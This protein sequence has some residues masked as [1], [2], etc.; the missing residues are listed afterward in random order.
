[1][2][3]NNNPY[4]LEPVPDGIS[5]DEVRIIGPEEERRREALARLGEAA[6]GLGRIEEG[7]FERRVVDAEAAVDQDVAD[8]VKHAVHEGCEGDSCR[9]V[10]DIAVLEIVKDGDQPRTAGALSGMP[11]GE[12]EEVLRNFET[13]RAESGDM[14]EVLRE[15]DVAAGLPSLDNWSPA[16]LIYEEEEPEGDEPSLYSRI[17]KQDRHRNTVTGI[18][19]RLKSF[20]TDEYSKD[21]DRLLDNC[22]NPEIAY[23]TLKLLDMGVTGESLVVNGALMVNGMLRFVKQGEQGREA[24]N[25]CM[26]LA[27]CDGL[28][29]VDEDSILF[30]E[31]D[32][33][34]D[35]CSDR[36]NLI[37]RRWDEAVK[38][39]CPK[40]IASSAIRRAFNR[41]DYQNGYRLGMESIEESLLM[42]TQYVFD[43]INIVGSDGYEVKR[44]RP[45]GADDG[46]V[47]VVAYDMELEAKERHGMS[48]Y[49]SE[50]YGS[51]EVEAIQSSLRSF[52]VTYDEL[53]VSAPATLE[54]SRT[55]S[56][57]DI[58]IKSLGDFAFALT[59]CGD[60]EETLI[61]LSRGND[62]DL[63]GMMHTVISSSFGLSQK[64]RRE[65]SEHYD[66]HSMKEAIAEAYRVSKSE[67]RFPAEVFRDII[68][69]GSS[70]TGDLARSMADRLLSP[71]VISH[72]D[73]E[74]DR[75]EVFRAL[76]VI[77]RDGVDIDGMF[78]VYDKHP[79]KLNG[80]LNLLGA[81]DPGADGSYTRS[82]RYSQVYYSL[83]D[84]EMGKVDKNGTPYSSPASVREVAGILASGNWREGVQFLQWYQQD[85]LPLSA[86]KVVMQVRDRVVLSGVPDNPT[87]IYDYFCSNK[88]L[89][90]EMSDDNLRCYLSGSL[91]SAGSRLRGSQVVDWA[92]Q[93]GD[94]DSLISEA[95][96]SAASRMDGFRLFVNIDSNKLI[97]A[98]SNEGF[99]RSIM[100]TQTGDYDNM[101]D[102]GA[103]Y[104][105]RRS[106][107]E[108]MLG[109]RSRGGEDHPIYGSCGFIDRGIPGGA[110]GYGDVMLSF[111]PDAGG[112]DERT[113]F[114]P[115]DSF[116]GTHRLTR[117]DAATLRV[118]KDRAG[119]SDERTEE[120]VEAQVIGGVDL[121]LVESIYV[122]SAET[123]STLIEQ[124]PREMSSRVILR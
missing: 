58:D 78:R 122:S 80:Y 82:E 113:T 94:V 75:G 117:E 60:H 59:V 45:S 79:I 1:M 98:A 96:E 116:H 66:G 47:S 109:N 104:V 5:G 110:V 99:L 102:R 32:R 123:Y 39:G 9:Y 40:G 51:E 85:D 29:F 21:Y 36:I 26:R 97:S 17:A 49:D 31:L 88:E 27:M 68:L 118:I 3:E 23:A 62:Y 121:S 77:Q 20:S 11:H 74:H 89:I 67:P 81:Y 46:Y 86:F 13:A 6:E 30:D 42:Q 50:V 48:M 57:G 115:E 73:D 14:G 103:A 101:V 8:L 93:Q 55:S 43:A 124:L 37:E 41:Y 91:D 64:F 38:S 35:A 52:V 108:L 19:E 106:D 87:A 92:S 56:Y 119:M 18:S 44:R 33:S 76:G 12:L 105:F 70:T 61:E 15:I 83:L 71:V 65:K 72:L 54:Q 53:A 107:V 22:G 4:L 95:R 34:I 28:K 7:V 16:E 111:R 2:S 90:A 114:T 84:E 24:A 25:M 100:D 112:M 63:S 69:A 120:Y 10:G